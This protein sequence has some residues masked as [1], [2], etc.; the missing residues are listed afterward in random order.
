VVVAAI[1]TFTGCA[2]TAGLVTQTS[3]S[4]HMLLVQVREVGGY[5]DALVEGELTVVA[6]TC[7]GLKTA[8]GT[9]TAVFPP[10]SSMI[11]DTDQV[12]V[13]GWGTLGLG[14]EFTDAGGGYYTRGSA[15]Y[16]SEVPAECRTDELIMVNPFR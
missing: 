14:D 4:G 16:S 3:P 2:Q 5:P 12:A 7:F 13:P 11:D 1:A 9:Y 8:E 10:G 6:D 15:E